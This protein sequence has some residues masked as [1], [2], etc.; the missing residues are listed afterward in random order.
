MRHLA[1]RE[2][3]RILRHKRIRRKMIGTKE[4]PRLCVHRSLK[5][6][7]AQVI[8][9]TSGKV[10]IGLSTLSK[11]VRDQIKKTGGKIKAATVLGGVFAQ[12][13]QKKGIKKV[14]FDRGGFLYHGRVKAFAEAARAAGMEF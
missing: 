12:E 6:L 11:N 5:N 9:D 14:C 4:S 1:E 13:A 8:D 10:I 7:S 3:K 2:F